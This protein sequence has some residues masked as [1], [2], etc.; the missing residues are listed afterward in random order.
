MG[1]FDL[2]KKKK[3]SEESKKSNI[4]LAMPMF[5]H[6]ET[7]EINKVVEYLKSNWNISISDVDG[8]HDLVT[9]LV[10]GETVVLATMPSPIPLV[11]IKEVARY[12]YNW[13]TAE[14]DLENHNAHVLVTITSSKNTAL[15]RFKILTKILASIVATT[16]C[17]GVYQ[18]TQSLLIPREQYLQGAEALN[19]NQIPLDLWIYIGL[20]RSENGNN[21]YTHG[22]AA[23]DKLDMEI[24]NTKLDLEELHNLVWNISAYVI[25]QDITFKNGETL[26]YTAEQKIKISK[27]AGHFVEGQTLKLEI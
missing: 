26:G 14:K 25:N 6:G 9:F 16:N 11:E 4:L 20:G 21:V 10:K 19:S 24:I 23:F 12:A 27:S 1:L 15:E 17:I 2:F 5:N 3:K 8:D 7:F 22:L 13:M 18:G